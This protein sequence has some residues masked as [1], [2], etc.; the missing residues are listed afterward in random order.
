MPNP[1]TFPAVAAF[2]LTGSALALGAAAPQPRP[3][4][5]RTGALL[6]RL[7]LTF[8]ENRG[9]TDAQVRFLAR[10]AG[11][12]LFLKPAE[13][14]FRLRSQRSDHRSSVLRMGLVGANPDAPIAGEQAQAARAHY[15]RGAGAAPRH[16]ATFSQVRSRNVY[17]GIDLVY[18]GR[19]RSLEYDFLVRPGAQPAGIRWR[20]EGAERVRRTPAGDLTVSTGEGAL[21]FRRP[22]CYQERAGR[23]QPV[24]ARYVL[25]ARNEIGFEVGGY[26]RSRPLVIDP[27]L[28]YSSYLGGSGEDTATGLQVLRDISGNVTDVIVTGAT[29]SVDFPVTDRAYD[30]FRPQVANPDQDLYV[31]RFN[32]GGNVLVYATYLGGTGEDLPSRLAVDALGSVYVTGQTRSADFPVTL[33]AFDRRLNGASDAFLTKLSAAGDAVVYSTYL[34]GQQEDRGTDIVVNS[35]GQAFVSGVTT[36]SGFP[37]ANAAQ[38]AY[39]GGASDGFVAGLSAN[40]TA[41]LYGTFVG[42]GRPDE[43][44]GLAIDVNDSLYVTGWTLSS[45]FPTTAGAFQRSLRNAGFLYAADAFVVKLDSGGGTPLYATYFGGSNI[46]VANAIAVDSFGTAFIAGSTQSTDLPVYSNAAD[47]SLGGSADAF[48]A[49]LDAFGSSLGYATYLGG[50]SAEAGLAIAVTATGSAYVGGSTL[51]TNFP[52]PVALQPQFGGKGALGTGDGFV[53]KLNGQGSIQLYGTYL[54]GSDD[55]AVAAVATGA[56]GELFVAGSTRSGN[57]VTTADALQAQAPGGTEA[58]LARLTEPRLIPASPLR[59]SASFQ[60]K[61]RVSLRWEDHSTNEVGFQIERKV[62]DGAWSLLTA[63]A[64]NTSSYEDRFIAPGGS[65]RYRVRAY[66][67]AGFSAYGESET[68]RTPRGRVQVPRQLNFGKV[69]VGQSKEVTLFVENASRTEP[70]LIVPNAPQIPYLTNAFPATLPPGGSFGI[71]ILFAPS[72]RGKAAGTL[73]LTTSD[74]ANPQ[75]VVKLNGTAK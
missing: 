51:S 70:L 68:V 3:A 30:H 58:F 9:Q 25:L 49:K 5:E 33:G 14:T 27:V 42:G 57:L 24:S 69:V 1:S 21:Q 41:L 4:A 12:S 48:V 7:P 16:A 46:D 75:V 8:E 72:F 65:Y 22:V 35:G 17:P 28:D 15:F 10:G 31:A 6:T 71:R 29:T 64:A 56:D 74:P 54:G 63:L 73:T 38:P 26:D 55:D 44:L 34:G 61:D 45:D 2:L 66:N 13:A 67:D 11:Y 37:T 60:T 20:L 19:Q 43:A 53:A 52:V 47:T 36:S 50:S 39:G 59:V 32:A 18:Y 23:R 62:G 40:G